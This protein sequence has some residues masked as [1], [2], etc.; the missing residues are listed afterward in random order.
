MRS[1]F[2]PLVVSLALL[3]FVQDAAADREFR[4]FGVGRGLEANV[5]TAML[6]DRNGLLWVASREGLHSYDGYLATVF[7]PSPNHPGSISDMDVRSLYESHDGALW[8]FHQHR[9]PQSS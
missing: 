3:A 4:K 2:L 7:R 9:R 6:I 8:V 1:V 5:V